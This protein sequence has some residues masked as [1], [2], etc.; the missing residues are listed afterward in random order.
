MEMRP[1]LICGKPRALNQYGP[2]RE[3]EE[4]EGEEEERE[5]ETMGVSHTAP[6]LIHVGVKVGPI[7]KVD[8]HCLV[9]DEG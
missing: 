2:E 1:D 6:Y 7:L 9:H 8:L 4:R 5:R 3:R